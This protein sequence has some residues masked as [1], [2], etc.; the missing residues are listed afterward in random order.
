MKSVTCTRILLAAMAAWLVV[1]TA[2]AAGPT[3]NARYRDMRVAADPN[4]KSRLSNRTA[5][6]APEQIAA[7]PVE[8]DMTYEGDPGMWDGYGGGGDFLSEGG[9]SDGSCAV[10]CG[11]CR[12]GLW[13]LGADY[14]LMRPR[15]S[16]GTAEVRSMQTTTVDSQTTTS[17]ITDNS[18]NYCFNY[19][20]SFRVT[21]GYRMLDCGGDFQFTYWRLTGDAQVSDGPAVTQ[22]NQLVITGQL[23]NN[24]GNGQFFNASTNITANI[25]DLDFGKTLCY[26]GPQNPCDCSFC[27]RWDM[28]FLAGV[29]IA[30]ISRDNNNVVTSSNGDIDST[31]TI[32]AR[33]TGAGPRIGMQ[34]RRYFGQCGRWSVFAKGTQGLLIGD[35]DMTRVRSTFN[36]GITPGQVA[37]QTDSF[38]RMIPV[39]DIEVGTTWQVTNYCLLSAGWFFQC[40]WDLGQGE[41]IGDSNFGPLDTSNVLSFDG[42]F[43]RSELLF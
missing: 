22:N 41:V 10:G 11:P 20:S 32:N 3:G 30:D 7:P 42:L 38:C 39:T 40:W 5:Q 43:V 9:C 26:G 14:L 12:K 28:R 8:G 1:S 18:V 25:Y 16:Q 15:L 36:G 21:A 35:Y 27:P 2:F 19:A 37:S 4:A 33:F 13:Y 34:G 6:V 17:T 23:D 29:R 31:G 24:P